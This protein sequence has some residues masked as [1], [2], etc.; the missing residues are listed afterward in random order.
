MNKEKGEKSP[1][2]T[3]F[4]TMSGNLNFEQIGLVFERRFV[5]Y[6]CCN[7]DIWRIDYFFNIYRG[8]KSKTIKFELMCK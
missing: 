7:F 2:E 6:F 1:L 5:F 3:G 8:L 4:Q